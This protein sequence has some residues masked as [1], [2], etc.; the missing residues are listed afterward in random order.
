MKLNLLF[1]VCLKH[2][3]EEVGSSELDVIGYNHEC[4]HTKNMRTGGTIVYIQ[5]FYKYRL[6]LNINVGDILWLTSNEIEVKKDE[7]VITVIYRSPGTSDRIF[8]EKLEEYIDVL[9]EI[10]G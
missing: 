1:F 7:Y 6:T 8:M 10:N 2:V 3:S 4:S 9:L 5:K